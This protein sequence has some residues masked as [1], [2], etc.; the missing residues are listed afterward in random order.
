M[1]RPSPT[2]PRP[3]QPS[4]VSHWPKLSLLAIYSTE[5]LLPSDAA[6][7]LSDADVQA[8]KVLF[9]RS[10]VDDQ[11][12][13]ER[14]ERWIGTIMGIQHFASMMSLPGS[15]HIKSV[16]T[17]RRRMI[18]F[19]PEPGF[20]IH[21]TVA[22]PKTPRHAREPSSATS[23]S[24]LSPT[25][26]AAL[27]SLDDEQL[28]TAMERAYREYRLRFGTI[29]G[30]IAR[31]GKEPAMAVL[32]GY[33]EDWAQEWTAVGGN[34]GGAFD[35]VLRGVPHSTLLTAPTTTQL[36]PLLA[37]FAV[38]NPT[39]LP[40]LLHADTALS[41]PKL[42]PPSSISASSADKP[43]PPPLSEDDLVALVHYLLHRASSR[44]KPSLSIAA[45][46]PPLHPALSQPALHPISNGSKWSSPFTSSLA[47][48]SYLNPSSLPLPSLPT[49]S[50]SMPSLPGLSHTPSSSH[51]K[52]DFAALRSRERE[53]ESGER[54]TQEQERKT[55][56]EGG[57]G[58]GWGLKSVS[59]G[60][61][62]L[63]LGGGGG[64][65]RDKEKKR[66]EDPLETAGEGSTCP[67]TPSTSLTATGTDSYSAG[68]AD[69]AQAE[70]SPASR[71]ASS[72]SLVTESSSTEP[73]PSTLND[74][75]RPVSSSPAPDPEVAAERTEEPTTRAIELTPTADVAEVADAQSPPS[76]ADLTSP[77]TSPAVELAPNVD[78][79]EL[80]EALGASPSLATEALGML[81]APDV[82][83][84]GLDEGEEDSEPKDEG[85]AEEAE[86]VD[87]E[88]AVEEAQDGL[89]LKLFCGS[90]DT[91][92]EVRTYERGLLTLA[93][94]TP[95]FPSSPSDQEAE[96]VEWLSSRAERLLE[97]VESVLEAAGAPPTAA[98]P[99]RHFVQHGVLV[100][101]HDP[102]TAT[103][104]AR[105]R[106]L[107]H[108]EYVESSAALLD[109]FRSLHAAP[110]ILES[111]TRLSTSHWVLHRRTLDP[112]LSPSPTSGPP[113]PT[114]AAADAK[115]PPG[116]TDVFAV[117]PPKNSKGR[118]AS[119]IDAAEELRR[120]ERAF[121]GARWARP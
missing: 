16:R 105:E 29:R 85:K 99:H 88:A 95:P 9:F 6:S 72:P 98:Y 46:P 23:S 116:T 110:P 63:G 112:I 53:R 69:P 43:P 120:L 52:K 7:D 37:Q 55:E 56:D 79:A 92:F 22:L 87:Q 89:P 121:G 36:H 71:P 17:S 107:P 75:S 117:L 25:D 61:G 103:S 81:E 101:S 73:D 115:S 5:P 104:A 58:G 106:D 59:V 32:Q 109:C 108:S 21:A 74:P 65:S 90:E 102:S 80:A 11:P 26:A 27:P 40:I 24:G 70:P 45:D 13:Q 14:R 62:K 50:L 28:L 91:P 19:Q 44:P 18:W 42:L 82:V 100:A 38:S 31:E 33:W 119:L 3:R 39:T 4:T 93:F 12:T 51:L 10:I 114:A 15:P 83:D 68:P 67:P 113:S 111:L 94:A 30:K 35:Q 20:F 76:V 77:L 66:A 96:A 41:L 1:S 64:G 49:L 118:D 2:S 47:L 97:A 54:A 84:S 34:A 48:P 8:S 86:E 60:W 78:A 57:G